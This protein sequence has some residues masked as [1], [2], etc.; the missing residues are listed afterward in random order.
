MN[1]YYSILTEKGKNKVANAIA[2]G[3]KIEFSTFAV[4]DSNGELYD[5]SETQTELKNEVWRGSVQSQ[6]IDAT[7][8]SWVVVES[9]IP[10]EDGGFFIRE[11]GIYDVEGDL[12]II[13][14][15]PEEYKPNSVEGVTKET[16][17]TIYTVVSNADDVIVNLTS[18]TFVTREEF[19]NH[20]N[21][22][23][24]HGIGELSDLETE[25]KTSIVSAINEVNSK[26]LE[27]EEGTWT[28]V[29]RDESDGVGETTSHSGEY[30][31]IG[32]QVTISFRVRGT[33]G[34]MTD[35][36]CITGLPF[37]TRS[38]SGVTFSVLVISIENDTQIFGRVGNS[39]TFFKKGDQYAGQGVFGDELLD[40]NIAMDGSVTYTIEEA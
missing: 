24:A 39:I 15:Y 17:V 27:Y 33:K 32:N 37:K 10:D 22:K 36:I 35:N 23:S 8:P 19:E 9:I 4:G 26:L 13:S 40:D 28:P 1:K 5:P 14:N 3:T 20:L 29:L 11:C 6:V 31:R 18:G 2:S 25:D 7:N 38:R 34:S 30:V 21:N 16:T 12:I